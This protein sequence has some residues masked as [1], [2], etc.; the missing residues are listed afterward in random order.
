MIAR[1]AFEVGLVSG[2]LR[3]S[4][5]RPGQRIKSDDYIFLAPKIRELHL[6]VFLEVTLQLEIRSHI[7]NFRHEIEFLLRTLKLRFE[8]RLRLTRFPHRFKMRNRC[9]VLQL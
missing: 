2:H 7:S 3:R 1:E 6:L 8:F 4:N 5:W 9:E